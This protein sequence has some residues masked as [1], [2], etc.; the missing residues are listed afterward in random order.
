MAAK[1]VPL[2]DDL[3]DYMIAQ[4]SN[5]NDPV[6]AALDAETQNLGEISRMAISH[7]QS[8]LM[9]LLVAAIGAK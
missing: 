6:L 8:S 1:Y 3:Y 4:R 9:T 2:N 5:A 7:E